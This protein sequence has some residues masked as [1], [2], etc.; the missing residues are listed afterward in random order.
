M[1]DA[2]VTRKTKDQRPETRD[3]RPWTVRVIKCYKV[4]LGSAAVAGRDAGA[5]AGVCGGTL[6]EPEIA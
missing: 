2:S 5:P 6:K 1:R 4:L 3:R